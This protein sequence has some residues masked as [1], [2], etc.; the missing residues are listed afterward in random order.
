[1]KELEK[2]LNS[3]HVFYITRDI[4]RAMALDLDTPGFF[5]I[6]NY[7]DFA[8]RIAGDRKNI[9][10]IKAE[11]ILDTWELMQNPDIKLWL[12]RNNNSIKPFI[13]VFKN[14]KQIE[15]ICEQNNWELLNPSAKLANQIEEKISQVQWLEELKMFTPKYEIKNCMEIEWQDKKFILQFNRSHTGSGTVL[16][17][18]EKQLGKI[19]E[20][21]PL[22]QA[23]MADYI[24][25]PLFTNN[26]IVWDNEILQGNIN[27]QITGLAPFTDL[28]FAAVGNDWGITDKI[29]DQDQ[30]KKYHE[31]VQAVGE[32]MKQAGWQG[33]FGVDIVLEEKTGMMYLL[34][35]NA[36]QPASTS[37]ES[38]L[39]SNNPNGITVFQAHLASLLKLKYQGEKPSKIT[40]G[41]QVIQ[42]V[43]HKI[44]NISTENLQALGLNL[45]PYN[46]IKSNSDLLRI[47]S[48][49]R[50]MQAHGQLGELGKK[51]IYA[52]N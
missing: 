3:S 48:R 34:E 23:R 4:E 43:T 35:I 26:N 49:T 45:I 21:F 32:K 31:I 38:I 1:M 51:I 17:E 40:D 11:H 12:D 6:S 15:K 22:R 30:I 25:G 41:A 37:Y 8:K 39:Q 2:Q 47:Q 52:I 28:P 27:Y 46:N 13:L 18:S 50:I 14:T 9:L 24:E 44:S 36:R 33:L 20:K 42:R 29:L 10:L 16:I 7:S 19:K 5:I